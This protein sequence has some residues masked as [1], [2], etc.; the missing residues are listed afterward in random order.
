[1]KKNLLMFLSFFFI[2]IIGPINVKA[3]SASDYQ[4]KTL[5][6]NY[7]LAAFK[8]DGTIDVISCHTTFEEAEEAMKAN[9][10]DEVG[11]L[12]IVNDNYS[13]SIVKLL[14]VNVG[15][16]DLSVNPNTLT[17]FYRTSDMNTFRYTYMD[18]G[19]LY[20]GV[21]G[22]LIETTFSSKGV[23]AA[24]VRIGNQTGWISQE[25]YEVV[26]ITWIKS[27]S[28]YTVTNE[29]IRHN[30]VAKIQ[31]T[32][33]G[34][35]GSIIG[36]KPDMLE[37]GTYYSY[38][39][40]Y[41][42]QD[43]KTLIKDYR[44]NTYANS[45]NKDKPY[46]NYYMYLS[47]HTRTTYSSLN[48]DE[49][50]RNN[51]NITKDAYGN[52][53]NNNSS[54]LYG[55]GQ[56]FYY[57]QEKYGVNAILSLSLSRN[58]TAHGR[59]SLAINKNN[60]FGLNAVDSNPTEAANWYASFASS[61]LGYASKYITYGYA[62]PNDWRYFGPQFG[63]KG[64]GMNVNYASDTYWSEKMAAN[65]YALD[66][67]KGLQD[68]NFYQLG[69]VTGPV[70]AMS[71]A[72][73]NAKFVY[74]YPEAE[75]A[76]VIIGE[77]EGEEVN[78]SKIWYQVVSD[79]NI[80]DSY[81]EITSGNYNWNSSVYLPA[82]SVRKINDGKNGYISP[83]D[84][85]E[86]I[87]KDYEYDLYDSNNTFQPKVAITTKD[88]EYYYD[89]SLQSKKGL[90]VLKNRYV[91][92]YAAAYQ[93]NKPVA[94]LITSDYW[95][96][97]KDWV[98]ADSLDF[99]T[100][101]YGY[102]SVTASGNQYTWVNSI[103]ED[104]KATL[105][106]GHYTN[107]YVPILDEQQVGADLW[108]KVPVNLSGTNNEFGWTL[109]QAPNVAITVSTYTTE[110]IAP[111]ITATDKTIVQGT[112]LN[113]LEDVTAYDKE[114]GDLSSK[115]TVASSN[116]NID[117]VGT[118][119]IT[120]QVIDSKN[121]EATKTITVT[122]T[123]NKKPEIIASDITIT[124]GLEFNELKGVSASDEE[125]GVI[126]NI[127]VIENNVDIKKVGTYKVTYKVTDSYNQSI[128]KSIKVTVVENQLPT[129][130]AQDKV[131][132]QN[133]DF[134][135]LNDVRATDPEDGDLT[136]KIKTITNTVD[137]S[138]VGEYKVIY[139]VTDSFN[140]TVTKEIK[141][142][143]IEKNLTLKDG[144]FYLNELTW[145]EEDKIYTI[146]G[147]LIILNTNNDDNNAKYN[148]I[149]KEKTTKA[150]YSVDVSSWNNNVPYS[151]GTENG[152]DYNNSW[153][154]G[155]LNLNKIPAGDYDLYMQAIKNDYY[156]EK[157]VTNLFNRPISKRG[158][159]GQNG[160]NFKV[161]LAL[162]SKAIELNIRKGSLITTKT[163]N[164]FRNMINNY[165]DMQFVNNKLQIIG[166]SYNYGGS[167]D[168]VT[169]I[170]RKLILENTTT[171]EHYVYNL[172][173]TKNG[174]YNVT[175]QD[176]KSKL[177]AWYNKTID[178][179]KVPRGTYAM[180]VYTK[181]YDS[182]DYGEINDIFASINKAEATINDK[183][184]RITLNKERFN[185]IELVV[186]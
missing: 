164:T 47:N 68:Y 174:S 171:Y 11:I 5:C 167:Y 115:V 169:E 37:K 184:Y 99:I 45:V 170:T 92:V 139:E 65:Y 178:I 98:S 157:L 24:K 186:E 30:Y 179:S 160:Y 150:E 41:F 61:I 110:N 42:Y 70:N 121:K 142:T 13:G 87:N 60:G 84:T 77:K 7:E 15:L 108:Y 159:D 125:D 176:G 102:V 107:S 48:I 146:S 145:N 144:E 129:I 140:H 71:D 21:D 35:A 88:T 143:V 122:V 40:H 29:Y 46:Y 83:N 2:F 12:S 153:F 158:E 154:K 138:K 95:Y 44:N 117:A 97:Q 63:D 175:S 16:L 25:A 113:E 54:R 55:K 76:V 22:A 111:T 183:T 14:D 6:G 85:T 27:T 135:P 26:P 58:E 49:Y 89:S 69:V 109:S 161:Q 17:N 152:Y 90:T 73:N 105:I 162:K 100:S 124:Q 165:D 148:L 120:Y 128:T 20:G 118:Y 86:Y 66:K 81:N 18:T 137:T 50:I 94:Y 91:M 74:S 19:S 51:M 134:K 168:K 163:S 155:E 23:W 185:R 80:D 53:S 56:F 106:S 1:M 156:T 33:S 149:L 79:L 82:S 136:S 67:S 126:T 93:N 9:G 62:E 180:I 57:A 114:D 116:L 177:Y 123:E 75:D 28:S 64:L 112:K 103:P 131:I 34:S 8:E 130:T 151:L 72:S 32:Y 10:Q 4:S 59:S 173:S 166:T 182:E 147:Y 141:V 36:P 181:T 78:G 31:N 43:L 133:T 119:T 132:Y 38:D 127:E 101:K 39:G 52:A 104:T 172:G 3:Y 96:D